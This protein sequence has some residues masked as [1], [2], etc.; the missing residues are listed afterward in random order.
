VLDRRGANEADLSIRIVVVG[1]RQ[2]K[3]RDGWW[4]MTM[5]LCCYRRLALLRC[6]RSSV[7]CAVSVSPSATAPLRKVASAPSAVSLLLLSI[8]RSTVYSSP[9]SSASSSSSLRTYRDL[10][11][12]LTP[13]HSAGL[14]GSHRGVSNF[15]SLRGG[16]YGF[17]E[18]VTVVY[19][20]LVITVER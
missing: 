7:A 17:G 3:L 12:F 20:Q 5:L 10:G 15:A 8:L 4:C 14:G 1:L 9:P 16:V 11:L 6:V 13:I 18:V 19:K 2:D